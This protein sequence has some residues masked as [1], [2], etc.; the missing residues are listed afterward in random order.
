MFRPEKGHHWS[1]ER[2]GKRSLYMNIWKTDGKR[3]RYD[4]PASSAHNSV[5]N[6]RMSLLFTVTTRLIQMN[7]CVKFF[8]V[9]ERKMQGMVCIV[10]IRNMLYRLLKSVPFISQ[11]V[12][13]LR[14]KLLNLNVKLVHQ[15]LLLQQVIEGCYVILLM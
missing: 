12:H 2:Q 7:G 5:D 14:H 15:R 3:D 8:H 6:G 1:M 9:S 4:N 10:S 11:A 13:I